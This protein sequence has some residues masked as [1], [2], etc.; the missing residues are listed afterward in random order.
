MD[1]V[2]GF[3]LSLS[4]NTQFIANIHSKEHA[5]HIKDI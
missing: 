1:T 3:Q 4:K 5:E 2:Q